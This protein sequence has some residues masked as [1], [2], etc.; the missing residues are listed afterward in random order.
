[1]CMLQLFAKIVFTPM[2]AQFATYSRMKNAFTNNGRD[3][4]LNRIGAAA[5]VTGVFVALVEGVRE[6]ACVS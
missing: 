4:S 2:F 5:A 6:C 1:M 3:D